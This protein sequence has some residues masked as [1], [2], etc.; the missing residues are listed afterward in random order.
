MRRAKTYGECLRSGLRV[1]LERMRKDGQRK[2]ML[3]DSGWWEPKHPLENPPVIRGERHE[4]P[5][6]EISK[7][8]DDGVAAPELLFDDLGKLL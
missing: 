7:P 1:P 5:A 8:G 3:V 6:P 2:G 4:V